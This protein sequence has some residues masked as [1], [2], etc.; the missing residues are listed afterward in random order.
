MFVERSSNVPSLLTLILQKNINDGYQDSFTEIFL[1]HA[2]ALTQK[3]EALESSNR[4][5]ASELYK[6]AAVVYRISRFPYI[7]SDIKHKAY[8]AQ[9]AV[10]LKSANLWDIPLKDVSIPHKHAAAG[11]AKDIPLYVR[12]PPGASP[13][14]PCPTILLIT[15]L[16]GHRPDNTMVGNA[17]TFGPCLLLLT[18]PSVQTN[19]S[20]GAGRL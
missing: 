14:K 5:E 2:E 11:D 9:K 19:S 6:R 15:G 10:Y 20:A 8:E 12:Y 16:D 3:A 17:L 13:E 7:C 1:P 4:L 18:H